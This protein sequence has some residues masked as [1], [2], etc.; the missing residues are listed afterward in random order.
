M[1]S[2]S[3][4]RGKEGAGVVSVPVGVWAALEEAV[5]C[6]WGAAVMEEVVDALV[7]VLAERRVAAGWVAR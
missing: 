5:E 3:S 1:S 2:R 7:V 6:C 4:A